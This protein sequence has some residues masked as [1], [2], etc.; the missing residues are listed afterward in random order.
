[1]SR[2][3]FFPFLKNFPAQLVRGFTLGDLLDKPWSQSV[4]PSLPRHANFYRAQG[5]AFPLVVD[6]HRMLLTHA[7]ALSAN[8]CSCKKKSLRVYALGEN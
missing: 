5:S 4:V 3:T 8:Q 7:L 1:M 2:I 6:F